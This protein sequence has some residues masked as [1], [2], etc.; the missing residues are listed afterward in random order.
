MAKE[1]A[2]AKRIKISKTQQQ[3][4]VS[5]SVAALVMGVALVLVIYC[6]K[7]II[8]NTKIIN[9]KDLAI[10]SYEQAIQ[11]IGV[12][13]DQDRDGKFSEEELKKC[14]PENIPVTE[15]EGTLR[16]NVMVKMANNQNLE[17]TG[18]D[19]LKICQNEKGERKDFNQEYEKAEKE[20]DKTYY[21]GMQ[22]MCSALR[23]IPEALPA[24]QNDEALMSSLNQVFIL[25]K[26]EP[27]SISPSGNINSEFKDGVGT[28]PVSLSVEANAET[29]KRVLGNIEKSIRLFDI[30]SATISWSMNG[31]LT[32]RAQATSFYTKEKKI[33]EKTKTIYA[34]NKA[35]PEK[36]KRGK[37]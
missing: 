9:E 12:C 14:N 29:T 28:I 21:M 31:K 24:K 15:L 8:F 35:K 26:W 6:I 32:L 36:N 10:K 17:S 27:E 13:K 11:R 7:T 3:I 19:E 25:S 30:N 34:S 22:K 16:H 4:L 5:V 20:E 1:V 18:R 23:V 37:K 2:I 33:E